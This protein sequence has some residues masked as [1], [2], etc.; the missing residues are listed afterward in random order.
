LFPQ[1]LHDHGASALSGLTQEEL[2]AIAWKLNTRPRK[3]HGFR[4]PIE[5]Y[6][7]HLAKARTRPDL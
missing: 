1:D 4:S 3:L 6:D 5:V 2:D 7:E